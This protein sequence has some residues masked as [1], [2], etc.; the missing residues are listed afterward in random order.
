MKDKV[1]KIRNNFILF[2]TFSLLSI[3]IL[4]ACSNNNSENEKVT[5]EQKEKFAADIHKIGKQ[6]AY[7]ICF[8]QLKNMKDGDPN[9]EY[10]ILTNQNSFTAQANTWPIV[11]T[12]IKIDSNV[13]GKSELSFM[14]FLEIYKKNGTVVGTI[15]K[16]KFNGNENHKWNH[17]ENSMF[18]D[19]P[20]GTVEVK[21]MNGKL[22][23]K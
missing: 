19:T 17:L 12:V 8:N 20:E 22:Q 5:E 1:L 13:Y 6:I 16:I 21:M 23:K 2:V 9:I 18:I 3:I 11:D 7:G 10:Q 15:K 4:N 14:L